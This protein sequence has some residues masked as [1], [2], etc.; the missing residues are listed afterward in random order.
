MGFLKK[1]N[2]KL[3]K[4]GPIQPSLNLARAWAGL[5]NMNIGPVGTGKHV[6]I[7]AVLTSFTGLFIH[8]TVLYCIKIPVQ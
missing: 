4:L 2:G 7:Q 3:P 8:C 1:V 6:M 5:S